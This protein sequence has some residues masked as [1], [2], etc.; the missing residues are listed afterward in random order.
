MAGAGRRWAGG[1]CFRQQGV[2][3]AERRLGTLQRFPDG[4]IGS[5]QLL[6]ITKK[7]S[8]RAEVVK[9]RDRARQGPKGSLGFLHEARCGWIGRIERRYCQSMTTRQVVSG[10]DDRREQL[11]LKQ[12]FDVSLRLA[13]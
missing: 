10:I 12:V 1:L 4:V 2:E 13:D 6:K 8:S 3:R 9:R 7:P 5:V 11:G